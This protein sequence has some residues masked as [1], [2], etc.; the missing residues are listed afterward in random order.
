[1]KHGKTSILQVINTARIG[2]GMK[3]IYAL[4]KYLPRDRF[5]LSLVADK[6]GYLIDQ[7]RALDVAV[8]FVPMMRSRLDLTAVLRLTRIARAEGADIMHLHGTRAGFFGA[9]AKP[10]S[11]VR[12][13]IYTVHGFSFHKDIGPVGRAVYLAVERFCARAHNWTISVSGVDRDEA[14]RL[15]VCRP[16]QIRTIYNGIDFSIF[17]PV[18]AN[19]HLRQAHGIPPGAQVVGT[20]ARL[21]PQKGIEYFLEM[22]QLVLQR[23]SAVRF[24]I[25]GEGEQQRLLVNRVMKLGLQDQVLFLGPQERMPECYGGLDVFVLSSLWEGHP[26]SLIE[27]L[28]MERPTIATLTSGSPEIIDDGETGFLVAPKNPKDLAE[29]VCWMLDH[30]L[31]SKKMACEGRRRCLRRFDEKTMAERTLH[32]YEELLTE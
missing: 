31:E 14:I 12:N 28:A 22:A 11:G 25:I 6:G 4:L 9:L 3:H 23:K 8:H 1:M 27:S 7:I 32:I 19:G 10:L 20:V 13:S 21:V 16:E 29:K 24:V 2:G 15:G 26:L 17:D 18:Q 5:H 30:P